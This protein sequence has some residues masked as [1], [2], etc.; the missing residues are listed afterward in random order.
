MLK[1]RLFSRTRPR[2]CVRAR[3]KAKVHTCDA[4]GNR[5]TNI[6]TTGSGAA[7]STTRWNYGVT[8]LAKHRFKYL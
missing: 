3:V 4:N 2:R 1:T 5:L 6:Q 7:A 8:Q